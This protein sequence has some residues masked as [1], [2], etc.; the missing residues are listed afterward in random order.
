MAHQLL[1]RQQVDPSSR[2]FGPVG[3]A[4]PVGP[5]PGGT[6]S[7]PVGPEDLAHPSLGHRLAAGRASKDYKAFR[8]AAAGRALG[9]EIGAKLAEELAV[10]GHRAFFVALAQHS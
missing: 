7:C 8:R 5:H 1:Q 6:R 2:Q 4:Q 10:H 9:A 3:M